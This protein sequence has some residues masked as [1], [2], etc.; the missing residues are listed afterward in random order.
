V[1]CPGATRSGANRA[2]SSY[3]LASRGSLA[4]PTSLRLYSLRPDYKSREERAHAEEHQDIVRFGHG[5]LIFELTNAKAALLQSFAGNGVRPVLRGRI[6]SNQMPLMEG[7]DV[8][9]PLVEADG[10]PKPVATHW[11][12]RASC[13]GPKPC[14]GCLWT[15][16]AGCEAGH[17]LTRV[18]SFGSPSGRRDQMTFCIARREVITLIGGAA[19]PPRRRQVA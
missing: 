16:G 15:C 18:L 13:R 2:S 5:I 7:G 19:T 10:D 11:V 8:A 1:A 6:K 17:G 14:T 9:A 12:P 3:S 4:R